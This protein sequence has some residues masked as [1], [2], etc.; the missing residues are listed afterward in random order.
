VCEKERIGGLSRISAVEWS[1]QFMHGL[2][3]C[4]RIFGLDMLV[5]AMT[6]IEDVAGTLAVTLQ[7]TLHFCA[8]ALR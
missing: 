6:Q 4:R 5:D 1:A 3:K 2:N 7:H 8:D